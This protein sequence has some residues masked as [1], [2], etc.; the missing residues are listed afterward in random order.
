MEALIDFALI[1]QMFALLNPLSS[2]PF[3][4]AAYRQKMN[5]RKIAVY[6][7]IT[8]SVIAFSITFVG[9]V[10]FRLFGITLDSFRIAGGV[11][12]LLLGLS[13]IH[14]KEEDPKKLENVDSL[15][16]IIAIP[17]LTGPAIMS[18]ITI[19]AY[20][21]GKAQVLF[22]LIY[23]FALVALVFLA[24]AALVSRINPKIVSITSRVIG[25]F[26]TAVGIEMI[27][28]GFANILIAA[29]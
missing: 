2:F 6:S 28:R 7:V 5:V 15:T 29:K 8:A 1:L 12:L 22:N 3:L 27:S 10:L 13:M 4:I 25:L 26:L 24:F 20:E 14:P 23:A 11:V 17:M 19:K 9:P 16:T 21:L 18:F